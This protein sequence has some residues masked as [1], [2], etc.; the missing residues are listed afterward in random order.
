[1]LLVFLVLW[2]SETIRIVLKLV[3][4]T[5]A[6]VLDIGPEPFFQ[7]WLKSFLSNSFQ[8][9]N[10]VRNKIKVSKFLQLRSSSNRLLKMIDKILRINIKF[11]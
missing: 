2:R 1:M 8:L 3:L 6:T 10:F 5:D 11:Q 7:G 4:N 9:Y